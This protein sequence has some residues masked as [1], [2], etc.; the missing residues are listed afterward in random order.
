MGPTILQHLIHDE[1]NESSA[2]EQDLTQREAMSKS[3][4]PR[5]CYE[6]WEGQTEL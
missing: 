5:C 1:R 3:N 2:A 6:T 4:L